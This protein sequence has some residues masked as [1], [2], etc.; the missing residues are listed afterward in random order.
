L[1]A[2]FQVEAFRE[3]RTVIVESAMVY[4]MLRAAP[5]T[6]PADWRMQ[7]RWRVLDGFVAGATLVALIGLVNYVRGDRFAAEFGLPRI[8]SVF[9]SANN[10]ALLLERV[11]P[12]LVAVLVWMIGNARRV[13]HADRNDSGGLGQSLKPSKGFRLFA[14][15]LVGFP[16]RFVLYTAAVLPVF[17][18]LLLTQSR[19]AL[20]FG[21]PALL[22]TV[23]W[24]NGR[25]SRGVAL[26]GL[27]LIGLGLVALFTGAALP[28]VQGT[29]LANAFDLQRGTGFFRLNLW[30]SAWRMWLDHFWLGVGPDNFLYAYR[31]FY[32]LPV[33]WKEPNLSHPHNVLFEF[34][35][36]LGLLGVIAGGGLI[37]GFI[38][39]IALGLRRRDLWRPVYIGAA[40]MLAA[41]L[42]HGLVD[43]SFFLIEL[44][45][46]FM[47]LAGV[48]SAEADK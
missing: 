22:I 48:C 6:M 16:A 46:P 31:S 13:G 25:R 24:L 45:F 29:R 18:A 21:L 40:G 2:D 32:I 33:A 23:L 15:R 36:R 11:L 42:A 10:D 20:L 9:G 7:M 34:A 43:Q 28:L 19:G 4:L 14:P 38:R 8:K 35:T 39:N 12:L 26:V 30:I 41:M 17:V 44:A 27:G 47:V 37:A 3:L 5:S 1:Q